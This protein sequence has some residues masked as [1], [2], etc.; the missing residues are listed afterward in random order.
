MTT[1]NTLKSSPTIIARIWKNST[2]F[3]AEVYKAL[4]AMTMVQGNHRLEYQKK[5]EEKPEAERDLKFSDEEKNSCHGNF[6]LL[7]WHAK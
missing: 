2:L 3:V 5:I 6:L 1:E 7:L 4:P